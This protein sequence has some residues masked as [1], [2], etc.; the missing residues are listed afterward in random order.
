M[1]GLCTVTPFS[2]GWKIV[3]HPFSAILLTLMRGALS[4]GRTSDSLPFLVNCVNGV[5]VV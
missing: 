2:P 1:L 5:S 4:T 3:V